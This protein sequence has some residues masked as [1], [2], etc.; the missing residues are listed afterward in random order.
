[1][2]WKFCMM[3][4]ISSRHTSGVQKSN[5]IFFKYVV[6]VH[7]WLQQ[8]RIPC[9]SLFPRVRS[10]SC[11][12]NQWCYLTISSSA[13]FFSFCFQSFPASGSPSKRTI[14][15]SFR[16]LLRYKSV[17]ELLFK[18]PPPPTAPSHPLT[19]KLLHYGDWRFILSGGHNTLPFCR[20]RMLPWLVRYLYFMAS[21]VLKV[22]QVF[23]LT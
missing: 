22:S 9:P 19:K 16:S 13:A 1:M 20:T 23:H 6:A 10:K 7:V 8:V 15:A 3:N 17:L 2:S 21:E 4:D 14:S 12:L 18:S 5:S 11:S